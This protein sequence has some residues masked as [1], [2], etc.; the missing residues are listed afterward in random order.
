M[1]AKAKAKASS[2][3]AAGPAVARKVQPASSTHPLTMEERLH[4][5]ETMRKRIDDYIKFMCQ[6]TE[7]TGASNE[8]K[9]RAVTV[10]Y[11]QMVI[12]ESQLG[13]IHDEFRLE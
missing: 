9:E 2:H 10:F 5:I 13:R 8:I 1:A 4:R 11:E 3:A 6:I 12:V 7:L